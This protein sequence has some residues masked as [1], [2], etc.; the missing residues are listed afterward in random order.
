MPLPATE[1]HILRKGGN[2]SLILGPLS[3]PTTPTSTPGDAWDM[4]LGKG[5]QENHSLHGAM[6]MTSFSE[7][8]T[9]LGIG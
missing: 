8:G 7:L 6:A 9:V 4:E 5:P 2:T 3:L 1:P